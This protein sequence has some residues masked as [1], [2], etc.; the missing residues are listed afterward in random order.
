MIQKNYFSLIKG[1]SLFSASVVYLA[2]NFLTAVT[3]FLLVPIL[4]RVLSPAEYGE[5]AIFQAV[6]VGLGSFIGISAQGAA[7]VKYYDGHS[8]ERHYSYFLGSCLIVLIITIFATLLPVLFLLTSVAKWLNLD[9]NWI[10]IAVFVS[11]AS[12]VSTI[13]LGQW[14]VRRQAKSFGVFQV[15]QSFFNLALSLLLV[16]SFYM[17]AYGRMLAIS[18]TQLVFGLIAFFLLFKSNLIRFRWDLDDIKEI[19]RFG[20]PLIPHSLGFFLLGAADRII[21]NNQLGM[22]DVGLYVVSFQMV[23]VM[24]LFFESINNAFVP[25]L[26]EKLKQNIHSEKVRIVRGTY[27]YF[28]VLIFVVSSISLGA[29]FLMNFIVGSKYQDAAELMGWMALGQAFSG[30][31]FMVTNY[32]FFSKKTGLLSVSTLS[33]GLIN[34]ALLYLFTEYFGIKGAAIAYAVSM[35]LKF[36]FTWYVAHLRHPMPWFNFRKLV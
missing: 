18:S 29:S 5:I 25:W 22:E 11:G 36:I 7:S 17:G 6:L 23:S 2:S 3:P 4:T 34:I 16:V 30:M 31:Y 33:S 24:G 1:G 26:F 28:L 27:L 15:T 8:S 10:V 20:V 13:R 12:F 19:C 9:S 14:Q 35:F 21:I 32:I